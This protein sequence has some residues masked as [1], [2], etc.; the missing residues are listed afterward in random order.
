MRK[1]HTE[2]TDTFCAYDLNNKEYIVHEFTLFS[3]NQILEQP[4]QKIVI[5]R[6][7]KTETG[8][9]YRIR[10]KKYRNT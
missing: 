5:N 3:D 6:S 1:T 4:P 10:Q 9:T 2:K 7:Y 8:D